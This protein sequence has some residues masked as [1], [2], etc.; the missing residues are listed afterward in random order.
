MSVLLMRLSGPMQAWGTRSRFTERD[1]ER[2]PSK[3]GIIGLLCAALGKPRDE[4]REHGH[5]WPTLAQLAGLRMGVRIDQEGTIRRDYQTA[6]GGTWLGRPYGVAKSDGSVATL[7][8]MDKF[9]VVSNRYYLADAVFLAGLKGEDQGLLKRIDAALA[10]PV[11]PLFL[12]RKAF[13][14]AEPIRLPDGLQEGLSL[15]EGLRTY[16]WLV[17]SQPRNPYRTES[18]EQLRMVIECL[19][20][21]DG[22]VRQ[23]VPISFKLGARHYGIRRVREDWT[24]RSRIQKEVLLCT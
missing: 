9:T 23:D 15:G 8:S 4:K 24:E 13:V 10:K 22:E 18:P 14:P 6:G 1:T 17:E 5:R 19:P 3:S 2:E 11:W 16:P 21:E 12:G 20:G 7:R